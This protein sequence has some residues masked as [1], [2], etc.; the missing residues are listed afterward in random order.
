MLSAVVTALL[1]VIMPLIIISL[2]VSAWRAYRC[3]KRMLAV[4]S[5]P[6]LPAHPLD[7]HVTAVLHLREGSIVGVEELKPA[8][9][10]TL[11]SSWYTRRRTLV[12]IGL[13]V[14]VFLTFFIQDSV[15]GG[16]L[17]SLTSGLGFT[18]LRYAQ[19]FGMQ[20]SAHP[21]PETASTR[22]V[23]VDSA[24]PAQ[25][26]NSYQLNV[27]SY[28]SC[29][30]IAM[31]MVMNAYGR[32]LIAADVLQ[33]EQN[34]GVWNTQLGLLREDGIAMTAAHF[35]FDAS[36]NHTRTIQEIVAIA[37]KGAP[38]IV[39]V[40]DRTYYPNGHIFVIKGGDGQYISVA[41]SSPQN[42]KRMSYP[43]FM[44]MWQTFNAVLTPRA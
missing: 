17:Q 20:L 41:D 38:V 9:A 19:P 11:P 8:P 23:R 24:S 5:K 12:S 26:Y 14:M 36:A 1:F 18:F 15:T 28:S 2:L 25:Y 22:V 39:S 37:N 44:G 30:G 40:R 7:R 4:Q 42:F 33:V 10:F 27:W 13:L 29:S 3:H 35:G 31:E 34:L 6:T 21:V 16:P 32:H 43:M